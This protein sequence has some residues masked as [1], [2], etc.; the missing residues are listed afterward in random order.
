MQKST[1]K[2][3]LSIVVQIVVVAAVLRPGDIDGYDGF[4]LSTILP[5]WLVY[6]LAVLCWY[7]LAWNIISG[8]EL[9]LWSRI[10]GG[11]NGVPRQRKLLTDML[12][13]II[14]F[15]I[16]AIVVI[17]VFK[18]TTTGLFATSGIIAI[19]LGVALQNTL[20]D[21]FAGLALNIERPYK[22][23]DW[24][25]LDGGTQGLVLVTNWRAT[26]VRTRT[27]DVL[28][29]PNGMI[30]KSRLTNHAV[31]TKIHLNN[32]EIP[33]IYGFDDV[34]VEAAIRCAAATV[35]GVLIDPAPI[36]LMHEMK[37][38]VVVWRLYFFIDDF[39]RLV[40]VR[41]QLAR[42]IYSALRSNPS[43][44][45]LPRTNIWVHNA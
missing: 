2:F 17:H 25:S 32:V 40:I 45:F 1:K 36:V 13:I 3:F 19:V 34:Q 42:A 16:S 24:I 10:F 12:N 7:S 23:G 6:T 14:Y 15:V 5:N 43:G 33:L 44:D 35:D 27:G 20:G 29:V 30:A 18:Q 37:S 21:L 28:I 26:H 4:L 22:A 31:P 9:F 41:G 11:T 39:A 38:D 8:L